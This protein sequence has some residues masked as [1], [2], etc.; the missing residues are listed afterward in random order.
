MAHVVTDLDRTTADTDRLLLTRWRIATLDRRHRYDSPYV[1]TFWLPIIGPSA[2]VIYRRFGM[3]IEAAGEAPIV[4]CSACPPPA[5][6]R[7][8]RRSTA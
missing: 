8:T 4:R 6:A 2:F 1:E 3:W 5:A 7:S